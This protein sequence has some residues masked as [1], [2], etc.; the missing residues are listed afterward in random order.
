MAIGAEP[1][2]PKPESVELEAPEVE[3]SEVEEVDEGKLD[4]F[5]GALLEQPLSVNEVIA[6]K[7]VSVV[8]AASKLSE[9]GAA[10]LRI[11]APVYLS[12]I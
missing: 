1:D 11:F 8:K 5:P 2:A 3:A 6:V 4:D 9:I 10:N 7:E 12:D